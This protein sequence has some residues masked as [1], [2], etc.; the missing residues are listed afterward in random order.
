M[1]WL[2]GTCRVGIPSLCSGRWI[3]F[4]DVSASTIIGCNG[5]VLII[6]F[7]D[8][9][10]I[11][12]PASPQARAIPTGSFW[13]YGSGVGKTRELPI[14]WRKNWRSAPHGTSARQLSLRRQIV[15]DEGPDNGVDVT[16]AGDAERCGAR[17]QQSLRPSRDYPF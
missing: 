9:P 3:K 8:Y 6:P 4:A 10:V 1:L 15:L 14:G 13:L 12:F 2:H 17:R 5:S 11:G 16:V 7:E